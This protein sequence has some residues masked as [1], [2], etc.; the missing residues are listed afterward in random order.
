M[1]TMYPNIP[2]K[3]VGEVLMQV[4]DV[5]TIDHFCAV[6]N[7]LATDA[8]NHN[9]NHDTTPLERQIGSGGV[10]L[11][12]T[13]LVSQGLASVGLV[14]TRLGACPTVG[15]TSNT[16]VAAATNLTPSAASASDQELTPFREQLYHGADGDGGG[17]GEEVDH[18]M[19]FGTLEDST[20][21]GV[22]M[23]RREGGDLELQVA[24]ATRP[25]SGLSSADSTDVRI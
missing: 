22:E 24:A 14:Q 5:V 15:V 1:R 2:R 16:A 7:R 17:N 25:E 4:P 11:S 18:D 20:D 6:V 8:I 3:R 23:V 12:A 10:G 19:V 21:A 13:R 9:L